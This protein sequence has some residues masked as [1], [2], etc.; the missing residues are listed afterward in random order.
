MSKT[1]Y[2]IRD[3]PQTNTNKGSRLSTLISNI[4]KK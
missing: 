1:K 2:L 3:I 4:M